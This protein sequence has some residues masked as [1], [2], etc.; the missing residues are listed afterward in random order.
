MFCITH[1]N[2]LI[3]QPSDTRCKC[4]K[5]SSGSSGGRKNALSCSHSHSGEK[6]DKPGMQV[7]NSSPSMDLL[8]LPES[9]YSSCPISC[10]TFIHFSVSRATPSTSPILPMIIPILIPTPFFCFPGILSSHFYLRDFHSLS[11]LR[12]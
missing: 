9:K 12:V 1:L 7:S 4:S 5:S 11:W 8:Y 10:N 2:I 3:A 6:K